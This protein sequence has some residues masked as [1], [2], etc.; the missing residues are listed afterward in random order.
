MASVL[1]KALPIVGSALG[2]KMG[3]RVEVSGNKACTDGECI[4]L[5]AFDPQRPEQEVRCWGYLS[6]EAAHVRYTDFY[7][8]YEGSVLR[9][10]LTNLL[11][12]VRIEKAISQEYPGAAFSLAEVVR[13]LV[14]EGRLGSPKKSDSPVKVL[15]DSLLAILRFEVLGQ[16]ALEQEA[17][18]AREV[19]NACFPRQTMDSLNRLLD[20]VPDLQST[21][22]ALSLADQIIAL[23]QSFSSENTEIKDSGED[24]TDKT[25]N[26]SGD[27]DTDSQ[28][29]ETQDQEDKTNSVSGDDLES[30]SA[31]G[32][33]GNPETLSG[34]DNQA[35]SENEDASD[36]AED[37][38]LKQ[39]L[40]SIEEDW[41]EDLF[42]SVAG[43]LES[44]S[45]EQSAG[46]S[47][48]TA[49]PGI[50]E[51]VINDED[52]ED[53]KDLLWKVKSESARLAAQ[54][55]G[56]VQAK[57]MT[58]D[59]VGKR[60]VRIDGKRL[61]RM[62]LDDG[63]LF[64]RRS[65]S[66]EI[67]ATVHISLDISASMR[68]RMALAREAVLALVYAL[69][70][71]NGVTVSASA[72]PGTREDRIIPVVTGKESTQVVAETLAAL[73]SHDSTPM[74]TG[75]WHAVH[76]ICQTNAERRLI[77]M[78]TDGAPDIDYHDAVVDL[79]KRCGLSGIDVVGLG[80]N[81]QLVEE[82]F[83]R[84]LMINQL[85][86]LKTSLFLLAQH[87]LIR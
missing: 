59:R 22:E 31:E 55:T 18:K 60:G 24:G 20:Q 58:R 3:V 17:I 82:L 84:S 64:K 83:P 6:H 85:K 5:P 42:E 35:V 46:F 51:V 72:Y 38:F 86:E 80:I 34:T 12:D 40:E 75:L 25:E 50:D 2:R 15:N 26:S 61:H 28:H 13:H 57:T 37:S 23:F 78:I 52:R 71:I 67:N 7:L 32:R 69:K 49:T 39:I 48:V 21:Q 30:D 66:I 8:D 63:R 9:R 16:K 19:V 74:A 79:V 87:W 4:W 10:R 27:Q 47:A 56:L 43:E 45:C 76:Q 54:L 36:K 77:L 70:Q 62:A 33:D 41:P 44:W 68:S 73:D 65:E 11:E 1:Q 81:V 29:S 14:A 53:A